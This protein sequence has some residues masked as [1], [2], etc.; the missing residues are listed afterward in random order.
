MRL[1]LDLDGWFRYAWVV[2]AS[3]LVM[4]GLAVYL[5]FLVRLPRKTC[6]SMLIAGALFLGGAMG[7]ELVGGRYASLYGIETLAYQ[8]IILTEEVMEMLGV[9]L[10]I[11]TLLAYIQQ[12]F[13]VLSVRFGSYQCESFTQAH[14]EALCDALA[15]IRGRF[16][17]SSSS[18]TSRFHTAAVRR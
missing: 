6:C 11:C 18:P 10:F 1:A 13:G 12:R 2:P 8:F 16:L 15:E 3:V 7:V 17:L 4:I 9:T 14:F 5:P